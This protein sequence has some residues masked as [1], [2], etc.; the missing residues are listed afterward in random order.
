M[1]AFYN[2]AQSYRGI[3]YARAVLIAAGEESYS[4]PVY[5]IDGEGSAKRDVNPE[6]DSETSDME[7]MLFPNPA[8]DYVA[9]EFYGGKKVGLLSYKFVNMTGQTVASGRFRGETTAQIVPIELS[10]GLYQAI[11]TLSNQEQMVKSFV[12]K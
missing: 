3:S 5:F 10:A 2:S 8:E 12:V 7:L 6:K 9:F 1:E 11:V 4:E